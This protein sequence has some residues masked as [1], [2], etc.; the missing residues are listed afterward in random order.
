MVKDNPTVL[1]KS[2][3]LATIVELAS[4][5][6]ISS[7]KGKIIEPV[8]LIITSPRMPGAMNPDA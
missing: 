2:Y 4:H 6:L 8:A 5:F 3:F 1:Y 7:I